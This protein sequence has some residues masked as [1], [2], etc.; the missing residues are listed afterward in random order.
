MGD[1]TDPVKNASE[2]IDELTLPWVTVMSD[3]VLLLRPRTKWADVSPRERVPI[4]SSSRAARPA[5]CLFPTFC[6]CAGEPN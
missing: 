4:G 2:A 1:D 3:P 6:Y 5:A